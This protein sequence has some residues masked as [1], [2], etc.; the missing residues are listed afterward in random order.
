MLTSRRRNNIFQLDILVHLLP[1]TFSSFKILF[2]LSHWASS[3]STINEI[4]KNTPPG[5]KYFVPGVIF[6]YD[7]LRLSTQ[8]ATNPLHNINR[9]VLVMQTKCTL[10]ELNLRISLLE[11]HSS[12]CKDFLQTVIGCLSSSILSAQYFH[13]LVCECVNTYKSVCVNIRGS[14]RKS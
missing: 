6:K 12:N 3:F 13:H 10:C 8:T 2:T 14:Y 11:F 1:C 9:L 7:I 4:L 5:L